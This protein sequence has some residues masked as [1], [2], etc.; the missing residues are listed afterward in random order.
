MEPVGHLFKLLPIDVFFVVLYILDICI[1]ASAGDLAFRI[2][3][4]DIGNAW[5]FI[6]SAV[7][8]TLSI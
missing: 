4:R 6:W 3:N 2:M 7:V 1:E 5:S 8:G